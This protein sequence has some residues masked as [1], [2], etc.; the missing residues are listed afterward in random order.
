MQVIL[1][2]SEER[3]LRDFDAPGM[4]IQCGDPG[5]PFSATERPP[6]VATRA[7]V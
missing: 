5:A 2:A 7:A 6:E 4:E 3:E 1:N